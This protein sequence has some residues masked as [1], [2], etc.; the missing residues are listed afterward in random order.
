LVAQGRLR[1]S[2]VVDGGGVY[3]IIIVIRTPQPAPPDGGQKDEPRGGFGLH[4]PN[5]TQRDI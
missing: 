5:Y 2:G 1:V 3:P 4:V